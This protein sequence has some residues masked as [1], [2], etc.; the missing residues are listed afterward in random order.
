LTQFYRQF[1][2]NITEDLFMLI[3]ALL[4]NSEKSLGINRS[5]DNPNMKM[6]FI[7]AAIKLAEVKQKFKSVLA[8]LEVVSVAPLYPADNELF[9]HLP[10]PISLKSGFSRLFMPNS[11]NILQHAW[12][13][14]DGQ[15]NTFGKI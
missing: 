15:V 7:V 4:Q 10:F 8:D 12:D 13:E 2:R 1:L 3:N 9:C 11:P 6:L 14:Q 5:G